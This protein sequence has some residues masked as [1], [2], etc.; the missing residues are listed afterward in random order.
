MNKIEERLKEL[1]QSVVKAKKFERN[2]QKAVANGM[3]PDTPTTLKVEVAEMLIQAL[4]E[5]VAGLDGVH[6]YNSS[7][8]N[9]ESRKALDALNN[10]EKILN[11]GK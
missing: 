1:E 6:R 4:R 2:R 10:I 7:S 3:R 5:A 9:W 11:G 8:D